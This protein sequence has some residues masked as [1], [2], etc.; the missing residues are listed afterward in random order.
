MG[1]DE[2]VLYVVIYQNVKDHR[3]G[4]AYIVGVFFL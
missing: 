2:S 3:L 4:L 1:F